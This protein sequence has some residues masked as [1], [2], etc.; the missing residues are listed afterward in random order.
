MR[1]RNS[2]WSSLFGA[3]LLV[4]CAAVLLSACSAVAQ[5]RANG[6]AE[7]LLI[8]PG[9]LVHVTV[10]RMTDLETKALVTDAGDVTLPL[11]GKLHIAGLTPA[12][13]ARAAELQ[14]AAGHYLVDPQVSMLV[15]EYATQTVAIMGEVQRPGTFPAATPR[16]VMDTLALAGGFTLAADRHITIQHGSGQKQEVFLPNAAKDALA[17]DVLV[18]PGDLVIV[19]K[20]GIVYVLGD[21]GRPGGYVMQDD[22]TLTVLQAIAMASGANRTAKEA[23]AVV[24]RR[25]ATGYKEIPVSLKDMQKGKIP[26]MALEE[27]DVLWVPFSYG[28]N[29]VITGSS[30]VAAAG[31][32]VVYHY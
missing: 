22:S 18:Y 23:N 8:G 6:A 20:A 17:A 25:T 3:V 16:G 11:I 26:D 29:L 13:A 21:V 31:S 10:F 19:P 27:E 14:Y 24:V 1:F 30:I 12:E 32:A 15:E 2:R 28:K 9:D 5:A 7:S 4:G